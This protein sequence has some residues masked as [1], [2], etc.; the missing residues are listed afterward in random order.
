MNEHDSEVMAGLLEE[1]GFEP[2]SSKAEA[3]LILLNTTLTKDSSALWD[4]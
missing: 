2:A 4:S 1:K 3:D